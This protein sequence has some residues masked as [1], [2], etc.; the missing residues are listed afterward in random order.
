MEPSEN[1]R[2]SGEAPD[3]RRDY[4]KPKP[5]IKS[6]TIVCAFVGM[7]A[8]ITGLVQIG[9]NLSAMVTLITSFGAFVFRL[10][11]TRRIG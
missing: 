3:G 9:D 4:D 5:I 1:Q 8:S 11:A 10:I 6:R 7:V 2:L